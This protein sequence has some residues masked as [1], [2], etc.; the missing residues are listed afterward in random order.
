MVKANDPKKSPKQLIRN[1]KFMIQEDYDNSDYAT[2][3]GTVDGDLYEDTALDET[4]DSSYFET[5]LSV[6]SDGSFYSD[7]IQAEDDTGYELIDIS[8]ACI[9]DQKSP[10][11]ETVFYTYTVEEVYECFQNCGMS[12]FAKD[13][14]ENAL[15]GNFF[16]DIDLNVFKDDPF[17]LKTFDIFKVSRIVK[18]GWKPVL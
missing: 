8:R 18:Y 2:I 17:S 11:I 4:Q 12:K 14:K 9:Q 15:D 3:V 13:C 1:G 6:G 16:K 10:D 5:V 7:I